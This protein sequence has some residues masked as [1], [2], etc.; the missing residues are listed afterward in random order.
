MTRVARYS[1]AHPG[2]VLSILVLLVVLGWT[3]APGL[4]TGRSPIEGITTQRLLP[5]SADHLF[6][7]DQ[8]GRDVYARVVH[9]ASP[10]LRA[11]VSA[12]GVA[13]LAGGALGL[14]AGFFGGWAETAIMR[15]VEVALSIPPVL[16]S[17]LIIS[18]LG[19]GTLNIA[20][21]VGAVSVAGFA[22]VMR[23]EVLRVRTA[24]YVEAAVL[25][26]ARWWRILL[27]YVLPS[28]AGPVL[29][30][31]ALDFGLVVL[32]VSSLSFLGYGQPPPAPEWGALIAGGRDYLAS[33]WW[34]TTLPGLTVA[35]VV[36]AANRLSRVLETDR[37]T[38]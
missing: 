16:L 5:P 35:A 3:L 37:S 22:R 9:G 11:A 28:A 34:L 17:L 23:A 6:G 1:A 14:F 36:L 7:T 2:A 24:A 26:G 8:L 13:L 18:A 4:F 32:A 12:I 25:C 27:R 15:V 20:I 21:A 29:A 38:P 19:F 31:A 33:A 10:S 30:L